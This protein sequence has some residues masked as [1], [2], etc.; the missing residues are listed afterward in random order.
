[1]TLRT[2]VDRLLNEVGVE[3]TATIAEDVR[4]LAAAVGVE[5]T[6]LPAT[7]TA[8]EAEVLGV[9]EAAA[10]PAA[11]MPAPAPAPNAP[12]PPPTP[13]TAAKA[14]PE[15]E[16]EPA[17]DSDSDGF[18]L[19]GAPPEAERTAAAREHAER[20]HDVVDLDDDAELA[21]MGVKALKAMAAARGVDL[22]GCCE[23]S[24][25]VAALRAAPADGPAAAPPPA[26]AP[27]APAPQSGKE[28]RLTRRIISSALKKDASHY[29]I[30]GIDSDASARE[31]TVA[32]RDIAAL[33]HPDKCSEENASEAFKRVNE[34][35]SVLSDTAL[36]SVYNAEQ[37]TTAAPPPAPAPEPDSPKR[38]K[39]PKRKAAKKKKSSK[40]KRKASSSDDDDDG[41]D[42]DSFL[43]E[44]DDEE[45]EESEVDSD[46]EEEE[47]ES[48]EDGPDV[49]GGSDDD[50][51]E[52]ESE[53]ESDE[54]PAPARP[55]APAAAAPRRARPPSAP[56][57]RLE[58]RGIP[59]T[60]VSRG[61]CVCRL[62]RNCF[63]R[64][65]LCVCG[66]GATLCYSKRHLCFCGT[67]SSFTCNS[68][69][70]RCICGGNFDQCFASKH[71][72]ICGTDTRW[73][74]CSGDHYC[75][76]AR[77]RAGKAGKWTKCH[78]RVHE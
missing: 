68:K 71:K 53:E 45:E 32:Y 10:A 25:I 6:T 8:L 66:T 41:D 69:N 27:P 5:F 48:E 30:L 19:T 21:G 63:A 47:E 49:I 64:S 40:K 73:N 50:D 23:K 67:G 52:E 55:R 54:A 11:T 62:G 46:S 22:T 2:R 77:I 74:R 31:I 34:V 59:D 14:K 17:P 39:R 3:R 36:R 18:E 70:H 35:N 76:C 28:K 24:E 42:G 9:P 44:S 1:M 37:A 16:P 65:H 57:T 7:V 15:P 56:K 75:I 60:K 43:A 12:A 20:T 4:A 33:I 38:R 51:D 13:P 72:C 29:D 78:A 61:G 26:P 58:Q